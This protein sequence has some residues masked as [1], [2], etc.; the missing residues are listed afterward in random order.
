MFW[1]A[2]G[3]KSKSTFFK[4]S[5]DRFILKTLVTAWNVAD[6]QALLELA[7]AYF[8][9]M[10]QMK[11]KPCALAKLLGFYTMEIKNLDSGN[12]GTKADVLVM[13]NLFY[14][15]KTDATYDLKGIK[16]R[17]VKGDA[18]SSKTF[19]DQEWIERQRHSP[20]YIYPQSKHVLQEAVTSDAEFL[21]EN[22]IMD[23]SLLVGIDSERKE[24][25]CGLVDTFGTYTFAKT[26]ESKA[27]QGLK[28]D[29][30]KE[31]T[32][33]PP[34]EYQARF[35][36]AIDKYFLPVPDKWSKPVGNKSASDFFRI[37][38]VL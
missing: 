25:I 27:K 7:P 2:H 3:G 30:E 15:H 12:T 34:S 5:D 24:L 23:Y 36:K 28:T 11:G 19:L 8:G 4:T 31:V 29:K 16:G 32:I 22:N 18:G 20:V 1:V 14:S 21:A 37:V 26:I 38:P 35:L 17:K 6:L 33:I 10:N 9:Y 13:E